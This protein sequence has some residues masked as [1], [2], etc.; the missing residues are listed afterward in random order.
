MTDLTPGE[1]EHTEAVI[2]AAQWLADEA[3]PPQ[4][5]IYHLRQRFNLTAVEACEAAALAG[6]YRTYRRAH[7]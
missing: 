3:Q 7:G 5:V 2:V 1:H 6:R 4:P